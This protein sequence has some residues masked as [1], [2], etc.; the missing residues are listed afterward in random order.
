MATESFFVLDTTGPLLE[1]E[2][3]RAGRW[4]ATL[5]RRVGAS[6]GSRAGD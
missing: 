6:A 2:R 1:G 3:H 4:A 5:G